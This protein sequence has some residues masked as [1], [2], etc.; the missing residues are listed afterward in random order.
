[1]NVKFNVFEAPEVPK[2]YFKNSQTIFNSLKEY[3]KANREMFLILHLNAKL[4]LITKEIHSIG[5]IDQSAVYPREI[6]RSAILNNSSAVILL[7][8]HPSGDP[9]PSV[10]DK[11]LTLLIME[12]LALFDIK[13]LDNI[14]LG[15]DSY[16]SFA[17]QGLIESYE[18]LIKNKPRRI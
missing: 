2:F 1:M 15:R 6:A 16:Y 5:T 10:Q 7:H 8:N 9:T 17:D 13:V 3:G 4:G 11:D 18:Y 14:I 12:G